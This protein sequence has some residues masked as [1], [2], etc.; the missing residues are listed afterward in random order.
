[1]NLYQEIQKALMGVE[2]PKAHRSLRDLVEEIAVDGGRVMLK[3][4]LL[5]AYASKSQLRTWAEQAV[6]S[7]P[8]VTTVE[9]SFVQSQAAPP[10]RQPQ[11]IHPT[12]QLEFPQIRHIVAVFSGKGGV[13][14][15]TVSVNLAVALAQQGA[16]VGLFDADVHGPNIPNLLGL[17]EQPRVQD[18][19]LLPIYKH[20]V[21]AMSIGLLVGG[22]DPLIWRGPMISKAINELLDTTAWSDLDYLILD[23]PPG[24][25]DAPLGLAQDV[26]LSGAIAVTTP[27]EV[28]LADVRRGIG[29]FQKLGVPI[30]GIV[31]NMAYYLCPK[32][33]HREYIFG[34]GGGEA[35]ARRQNIPLLGQIPLDPKL[36]AGGDAGVPIVIAE[37]SSPAAQEFHKIAKAVQERFNSLDKGA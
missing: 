32:C 25:G 5:P 34:Q 16:R 4:K 12:K 33:G 19:K 37:P 36:R 14:K 26:K 2:I 20:G 15:S 27:Q 13:G 35:E 7:V 22:G 29:A 10:R 31:E 3:L 28:A 11:A 1:M 30:W 9:V 21:Y 24:T 17:N 18:G 6:R 23:L 8:G